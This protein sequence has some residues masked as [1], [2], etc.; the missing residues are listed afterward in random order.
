MRGRVGGLL[1]VVVV[2][3]PAFRYSRAARAEHRWIGAKCARGEGETEGIAAAPSGTGERVA[4]ITHRVTAWQRRVPPAHQGDGVRRLHERTAVLAHAC[5]G[6]QRQ[7][8]ST[9]TVSE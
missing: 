1:R 6:G 9:S 5:E 8:A 4:A 2:L 3:P 7:A